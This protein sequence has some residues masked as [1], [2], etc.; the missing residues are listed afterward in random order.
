LG[1]FKRGESFGK[2]KGEKEKK[3]RIFLWKFLE[4]NRR[5]RGT[6]G[7]KLQILFGYNTNLSVVLDFLKNKTWD[8][9]VIWIHVSIIQRSI[10]FYYEFYVHLLC[11][12]FV[13]LDYDDMNCNLVS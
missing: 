7:K 3:I 10:D 9:A 4:K 6:C 1:W 8:Y 11:E 2:Q 13:V 5:A 12:F